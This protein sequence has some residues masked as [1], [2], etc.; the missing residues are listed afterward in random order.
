MFVSIAV[1][2]LLNT[3]HDLNKYE[4]RTNAQDG[5]LSATMS[6]CWRNRLA[7]RRVPTS[8]KAEGWNLIGMDCNFDTTGVSCPSYYL[9]ALDF[10]FDFKAANLV[11]VAVLN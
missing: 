3:E 1:R 11:V 10:L 7:G 6:T 9:E 2:D 8:T 5:Q 4:S